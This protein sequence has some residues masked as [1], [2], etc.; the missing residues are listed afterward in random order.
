[1]AEVLREVNGKAL[2]DLEDPAT[3]QQIKPASSFLALL[4]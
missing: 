3:K 4:G 2:A 1:L